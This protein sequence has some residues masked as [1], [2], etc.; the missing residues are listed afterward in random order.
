MHATVSSFEKNKNENLIAVSSLAGAKL[1]RGD[2]SISS[3]GAHR[4]A[5]KFIRRAASEKAPDDVDVPAALRD[6]LQPVHLP[7]G[8][9]GTAVK[10]KTPPISA[11]FSVKVKPNSWR[12]PLTKI[13]SCDVIVTPA[14][15]QCEA[16]C[17]IYA[18]L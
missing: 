15:Y 14:I 11:P 16:E 3:G 12:S 4:V 17:W 7:P 18:V 1:S 6:R 10:S 13:Q 8:T 9:S 2:S 5:E